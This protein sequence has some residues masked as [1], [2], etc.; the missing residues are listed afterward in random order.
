MEYRTRM[1]RSDKKLPYPLRPLLESPFGYQTRF[2]LG[3]DRDS[4]P[5]YDRAYYGISSE[6]LDKVELFRYTYPDRS[7]IDLNSRCENPTI[8]LNPLEFYSE[9]IR[10][11]IKD[12]NGIYYIPLPVLPDDRI[13][14]PTV[15]V[16]RNEPKTEITL[17]KSYLP[18]LRSGSDLPQGQRPFP[19]GQR[20]SAGPV[21]LRSPKNTVLFGTERYN[22]STTKTGIVD[23]P[24]KE[25][26]SIVRLYTVPSQVEYPVELVWKNNS[27]KEPKEQ[28]LGFF[29]KREQELL[30]ENL[31]GRSRIFHP[32]SVSLIYPP[33]KFSVD[34]QSDFLGTLNTKLYKDE[35]IVVRIDFGIIL[36]DLETDLKSCDDLKSVKTVTVYTEYLQQFSI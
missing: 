15:V 22:F 28:S 30:G 18:N 9:W 32:M 7:K 5:L 14:T 10:Q 17:Y 29:S 21:D 34:L 23:F 4:F 3:K 13:R 11:R 24:L 20:P 35:S 33:D 36:N 1:L 6:D 27:K 8:G 31:Q 12:V 25:N 2:V 16:V 26:G 19:Q